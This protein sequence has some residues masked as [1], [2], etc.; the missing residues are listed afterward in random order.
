MRDLPNNFF[1]ILTKIHRYAN[2]IDNRTERQFDIEIMEIPGQILLVG[3]WMDDMKKEEGEDKTFKN[4]PN[5]ESR[6]VK[7]FYK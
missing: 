6:K 3:G 2:N 5:C 1:V 4:K 7:V